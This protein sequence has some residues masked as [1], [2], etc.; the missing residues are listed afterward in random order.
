MRP[1]QVVSSRWSGVFEYLQLYAYGPLVSED[2]SAMISLLSK[3]LPYENNNPDMYSRYTQLIRFASCIANIVSPSRAVQHRPMV[4]GSIQVSHMDSAAFHFSVEHTRYSIFFIDPKNISRVAMLL[5]SDSGVCSGLES[6][7]STSAILS[8]RGMLSEIVDRQSRSRSNAHTMSDLTKIVKNSVRRINAQMHRKLIYGL[9]LRKALKHLQSYPRNKHYQHAGAASVSSRTEDGQLQLLEHVQH[10]LTRANCYTSRPKLTGNSGKTLRHRKGKDRITAPFVRSEDPAARA[11]RTTN[12]GSGM[13]QSWPYARPSESQSSGKDFAGQLTGH[14]HD[15]PEQL[16]G[17]YVE[18]ISPPV[19]ETMNEDGPLAFLSH[20]SGLG[21]PHKNT[22]ITNIEQMGSS[23]LNTTEDISCDGVLDLTTRKELNIQQPQIHNRPVRTN[24]TSLKK[25]AFEVRQ[26][27]QSSDN[28]FNHTKPASSLND[29]FTKHTFPNH[30]SDRISAKM[31]LSGINFSSSF[32]FSCTPPPPMDF[33]A[34]VCAAAFAHS[35]GNAEVLSNSLA[36]YINQPSEGLIGPNTA[37]P[38]NELFAMASLSKMPKCNVTNNVYT[39]DP[40]FMNETDSNGLP[41]CARPPAMLPLSLPLSQSMVWSPSVPLFQTSNGERH[42]TEIAPTDPLKMPLNFGL[43]RPNTDQS[44]LDEVEPEDARPDRLGSPPGSRSRPSEDYLEQFM[45][46]DQTQNILWRQLAD[47]FQR[48]LAPNQC[49]VCNKVLSCRSAL[50]MHYRVHTEER[51]FVCIICEK[52]FST[53]GNLKTHLGQHHETIEAYR[54]AVA[55]AMA[56]GTA[57]PRPPP[58]SSSAALPPPTIKVNPTESSSPS[59]REDCS[60]CSLAVAST[61]ESFLQIPPSDLST[62][63][64]SG[65]VQPSWPPAQA[66]LPFL[67]PA[68]SS[69]FPLSAAR[70]SNPHLWKCDGNPLTFSSA[71]TKL[72]DSSQSECLRQF[73]EQKS[74][75]CL[76]FSGASGMAAWQLLGEQIRQICPRPQSDMKFSMPNVLPR[77]SSTPVKSKYSTEISPPRIV[78]ELPFI[79]L[80]KCT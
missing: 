34:V 70:L 29:S 66:I 67:N 51:P 16:R 17:N 54:N 71:V 62:M 9:F 55:V 24:A 41:T 6:E 20:D 7:G 52:R 59:K 2:A 32:P 3:R 65:G 46:V 4:T 64:G 73:D 39:G 33:L 28:S 44:V 15:S 57:L 58:M 37:T 10:L 79:P 25:P 77:N 1:G 36:H 31:N 42:M 61:S 69:P 21:S 13:E 75:P 5:R 48:T 50:T 19:I 22:S 23:G 47:R 60:P 26:L 8:E 38:Q 63:V 11:K 45:K 76:P 14:I 43:R 68:T 35:N 18:R 27:R 30:Y 49:G 53:K 72:A 74:E 56:T 12:L 80:E 78:N 40:A